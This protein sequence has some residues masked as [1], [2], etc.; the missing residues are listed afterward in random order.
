M[1]KYAYIHTY[2]HTY[3]NACR[4]NIHIHT[5]IHTYALAHSITIQCPSERL[6]S[7]YNIQDY[8]FACGCLWFSN[9]VSDIK[10]GTQTE[11]V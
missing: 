7:N 5:C 1:H 8:N 9:L 11:G 3:N 4:V 6:L 2:I 10:G